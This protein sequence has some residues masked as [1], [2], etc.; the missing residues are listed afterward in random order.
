SAAVPAP[1][2][3]DGVARGVPPPRAI[4]AHAHLHDPRLASDLDDVVARATRAGVERI[5]SCGEDFASSERAI[6]VAVRHPSVRVAVGV[7]PH[8][9]ASWSE[10][11]APAQRGLAT[12][13]HAVP[14]GGV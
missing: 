12:K 11:V 10:A 8:R 9:A 6:A 5:L 2:A 1:R 14:T 4:D 7:H 3:R 13:P